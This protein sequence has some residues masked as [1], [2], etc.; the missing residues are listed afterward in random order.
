MSTISTA[1]TAIRCGAESRNSEGAIVG[2]G[3]G[4]PL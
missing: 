1:A 4:A 2:A 3:W